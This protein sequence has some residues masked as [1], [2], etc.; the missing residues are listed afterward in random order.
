M[1]FRESLPGW[2]LTL[3][4]CRKGRRVQHFATIRPAP[5]APPTASPIG[6]WLVAVAVLALIV[7]GGVVL[8]SRR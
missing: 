1:S 7:A 2:K 6:W 5:A 8:S 4:R 3:T